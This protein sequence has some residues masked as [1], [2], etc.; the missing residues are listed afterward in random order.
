[1]RRTSFSG[2]S[3]VTP[4]SMKSNGRKQKERFPILSFIIRRNFFNVQNVGESIGKDLTWRICKRK[5]QSCL[6][7]LNAKQTIAKSMTLRVLSFYIF[8][9]DERSHNND[10]IVL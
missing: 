6:E 3:S 9:Y 7:A 8:I 4:S 10:D 1:M 5:L 2:V